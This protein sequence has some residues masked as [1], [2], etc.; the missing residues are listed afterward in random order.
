MVEVVL[1][2]KLFG[3]AVVAGLGLSVTAAAAGGS[4]G[5]YSRPGIWSGLY[6]GLSLGRVD[7]GNDDGIVGGVQLG[8]NWQ[9]YN[10]VYGVEGDIG[11]SNSDRIDS[12]G[13]VRGRLGY[14]IQPNLLLY[15]TAGLGFVNANES[16]TGFVWGVGIENKFTDTMSGRVEFL[17]FSN[18]GVHGDDVNVIRAGL[19]F[20]LGIGR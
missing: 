19:N 10:I 13:S 17:Q 16:D 6:G 11:V 15:G 1:R 4:P 3:L 2:K 9:N 12:L 14:L 20:K 7:S 8:Y 5:S 18:D